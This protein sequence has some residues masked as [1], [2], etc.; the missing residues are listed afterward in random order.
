MDA[1]TASRTHAPASP[2]GN[3][4][5]TLHLYLASGEF[6]IAD[7]V[8]LDQDVERYVQDLEEGLVDPSF[9]I[10]TWSQGDLWEEWEECLHGYTL[11]WKDME[12]QCGRKFI[13]FVEDH[14]M[15]VDEPVDVMVGHAIQSTGRCR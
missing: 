1:P 15:P 5:I 10:D 11:V 3:V 7:R 12:L 13:D 4:Y 8:P 6:I 2:R 14:G 9:R